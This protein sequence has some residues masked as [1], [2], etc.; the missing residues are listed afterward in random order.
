MPG[1][2]HG[3]LPG[4][5]NRAT[6]VVNEWHSERRA[7]VSLESVWDTHWGEILE[8]FDG[9]RGSGFALVLI[10]DVGYLRVMGQ[11][12]RP[13]DDLPHAVTLGRHSRCGLRIVSDP[14]VALRHLVL[15][16]APSSA[17]LEVLDLRTEEGFIIDGIGAA[18]SA[19]ADGAISLS[20]AGIRLVA[21]PLCAD[22]S[23]A[24]SPDD[25]WSRFFASPAIRVSR[26]LRRTPVAHREHHTP[27]TLVSVV[28][29]VLHLSDVASFEDREG[30]LEYGNELRVAR[31]M[32]EGPF[33][34]TSVP[35]SD[36]DLQRG[37]LVGRYD[38][39]AG[40]A[41]GHV[42]D[43]AVSRVHAL[44][45]RDDDGQVFLIDTGSTFGSVINHARTPCAQLSNGQR[46]WLSEQSSLQY[47]EMQ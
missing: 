5:E 30:D 21:L 46:A 1:P 7:P 13:K 35:L 43:Q 36:E 38:R 3:S 28:E 24:S 23:W 2:E 15:A 6:L 9:G 27:E 19:I 22:T 33:G 41:G 26:E 45:K 39:C 31:V 8:T 32:L 42:F 14:Y 18:R 17:S 11:L 10:D 40:S 16:L 25:A 34:R 44:L 29:P 47:F 4:Y 37:V 12:I 20:L